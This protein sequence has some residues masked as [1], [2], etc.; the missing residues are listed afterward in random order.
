MIKWLT[1][2]GFGAALILCAAPGSV[3]AQDDSD[4]YQA[5]EDSDQGQAP[6]SEEDSSSDSSAA[7]QLDNAVEDGQEAVDAP[8]DE[9]AKEESNETFDTPHDSDGN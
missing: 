6:Q 5:Q 3:Y 2:L 7:N 9:D 4:Q 8:T 1:A